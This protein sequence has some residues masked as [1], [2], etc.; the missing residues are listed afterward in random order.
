MNRTL[1]EDNQTISSS[2][3]DFQSKEKMLIIRTGKVIRRNMEKQMFD[4]VVVWLMEESVE[5]HCG[6]GLELWNRAGWWL[7]SRTW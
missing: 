4:V 2:K 6:M 7:W 1:V 3:K 5:I